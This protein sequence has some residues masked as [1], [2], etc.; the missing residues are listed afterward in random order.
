M[1]SE[2]WVW[3]LLIAAAAAVVA[4]ALWLGRGFI[5]RKDDKGF[6]IEVKERA[7]EAPGGQRI[8]VASDA[9]IERATTGDIGGVIVKGSGTAPVPGQ[10]IDVL[11]GGKIKDA[12]V[13]DIAGVKQ[14]DQGPGRS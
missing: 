12:T 14:Q 3:A 2:P 9:R 11:A 4:I 8:S 13:G 5:V 6:A 10:S 1:P 7:G